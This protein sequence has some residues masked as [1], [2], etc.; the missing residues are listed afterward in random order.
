MMARLDLGLT[1]ERLRRRILLRFESA[2]TLSGIR[3]LENGVAKEPRADY[4]GMYAWALRA[5]T[6]KLEV[7]RKQS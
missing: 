2:P 7:F 4:R 6:I 5:S 1:R 3:D